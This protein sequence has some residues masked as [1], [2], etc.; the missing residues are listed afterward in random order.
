M[1]VGNELYRL[2]KLSL[3]EAGQIIKDRTE[4]PTRSALSSAMTVSYWGLD[5]SS[6]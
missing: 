6:L 3:R 1:S 5:G 4:I 2:K